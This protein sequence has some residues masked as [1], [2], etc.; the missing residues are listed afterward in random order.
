[1]QNVE[2]SFHNGTEYDQK[3]NEHMDGGIEQNKGIEVDQNEDSNQPPRL[4]FG[5]YTVYEG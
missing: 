5:K 4:K 1:M 2:E 3:V